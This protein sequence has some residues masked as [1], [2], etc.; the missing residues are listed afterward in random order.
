MEMGFPSVLSYSQWG[1]PRLVVAWGA[2]AS[3]WGSVSDRDPSCSKTYHYA[4]TPNNRYTTAETTK[5]AQRDAPSA[6]SKSESVKR[7]SK[8]IFDSAPL[9]PYFSEAHA[10]NSRTNTPLANR[11]LEDSL[12]LSL[13]LSLSLLHASLLHNF[14]SPAGPRQKKVRRFSAPPTRF[15]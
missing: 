1:M 2:A 5:H 12:L 8:I 11:A 7:F 14:L 3:D 15:R 4:A 13:I 6:C 10:K 9:R